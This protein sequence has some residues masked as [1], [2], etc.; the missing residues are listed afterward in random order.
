MSLSSSS[1]PGR[2][3]DDASGVLSDEPVRRFETAWRRSP[4]AARP[5]GDGESGQH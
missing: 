2:A 4:P 3:W 1:A 5:A